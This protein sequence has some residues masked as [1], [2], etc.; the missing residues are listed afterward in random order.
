[1]LLHNSFEM[2]EVE[3]SRAHTIGAKYMDV[4][5]AASILPEV[6]AQTFRIVVSC[7][8]HQDLSGN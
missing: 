6:Y 8:D 3:T 7:L 4:I 2:S 5:G 1:M